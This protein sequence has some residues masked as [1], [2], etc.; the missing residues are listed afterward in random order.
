MCDGLKGWTRVDGGE[1][2][3]WLWVWEGVKK[4]DIMGHVRRTV[5]SG[6]S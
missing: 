6:E 5:S 2:L 4:A 3:K 1:R